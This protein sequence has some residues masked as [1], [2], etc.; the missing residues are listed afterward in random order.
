MVYRTTGFLSCVNNGTVVSAHLQR[1][2]VRRMEQKSTSVLWVVAKERVG[3][4]HKT[5]DRWRSRPMRTPDNRLEGCRNYFAKIV[6][7]KRDDSPL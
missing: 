7:L 6:T 5:L 4:Q 1:E 3:P 2:S